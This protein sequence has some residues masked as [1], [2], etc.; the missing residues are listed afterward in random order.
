MRSCGIRHA[1]FVSNPRRTVV[2]SG[3]P[4]QKIRL[5]IFQNV[6]FLFRILE[7]QI[8]DTLITLRC[9]HEDIFSILANLAVLSQKFYQI[10]AIPPLLEEEMLMSAFDT[11][12]S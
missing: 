9:L 5:S 10:Q 12:S 11:L 6:N 2:L 1:C 7:P 4:T 3:K 8:L